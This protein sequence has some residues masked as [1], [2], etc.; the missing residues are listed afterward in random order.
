[1]QLNSYYW[2]NLRSILISQHFKTLLPYIKKVDYS[3][4]I[5]FNYY[6][7]FF[8][9]F[10]IVFNIFSG[11]LLKNCLINKKKLANNYN[12][13]IMIF[14]VHLKSFEN[15][16]NYIY[17]YLPNIFF[18][19]KDV[20]IYFNKVNKSGIANIQFKNFNNIPLFDNLYEYLNNV[21]NY[22]VK[23]QCLFHIN[24]ILY[25]KNQFEL[26]LRLFFKLPM[27][28]KYIL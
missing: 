26:Y 5:Y 8:I 12:N 23:L 15:L 6:K 11:L 25:K 17:Y 21:M 18:T 2:I 24:Y 10:F 28:T 19:V 4:I 13:L 27:L 9:I 14:R 22:F 1:M 7:K 16:F 20:N 3:F